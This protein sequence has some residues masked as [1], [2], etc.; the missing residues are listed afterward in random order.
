MATE[1]QN[2]QQKIAF[3]I[4]AQELGVDQSMQRSYAQEF[5]HYVRALRQNW[6]QGT[7]YTKDRSE[8]DRT[9]QKPW[10]QKGTGRARAGTPRSPIWKGGGIIFGPH[11][12]NRTLHV[13]KA[14]R[15]NAMLAL[16]QEK[17]QNGTI[18]ALDADISQ[19]KTAHA[20]RALQQAGLD[21][22]SITLL[23]HIDDDAVHAAFANIPTV[24][25]VFF[26]Q[27]NAYELA[28]SQYWVLLKKDVDKLKQMVSSWI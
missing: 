21:N 5:A 16:L 15:R 25:L 9:T 12:R 17:L 28:C 27:P 26:D 8:V 19:P 11:G 6:R 10:R 22:T 13:N 20:A 24:R 14:T 3:P 7:A 4:T 1:K 2:N 18:V 23:S